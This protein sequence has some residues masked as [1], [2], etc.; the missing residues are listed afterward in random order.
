[1]PQI[2]LQHLR[3]STIPGIFL[4]ST[5]V[6]IVNSA[7][8]RSQTQEPVFPVQEAN[9]PRILVVPF[10]NLGAPDDA[11]LAAGLT[12]EITNRLAAVRGI[13]FVSRVG[14][15]SEQRKSRIG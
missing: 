5:A 4:A 12:K 10:E 6:L 11:F 15:G 13:G 8:G 1:M 9:V 7:C 3:N 14:G 2:R